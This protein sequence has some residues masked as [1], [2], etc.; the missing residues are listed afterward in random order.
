MIDVCCTYET[1]DYAAAEAGETDDRGYLWQA[2]PHTFRELVAMM[3]EFYQP[4]DY[5]VQPGYGRVSFSVNDDTDCTTGTQ[6]I[7]TIHLSNPD[8][9]RQVRYWLKAYH[10][11][12][13]DPFA[14]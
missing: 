12:N 7:R 2:V 13:R 9:A 10:T 4:S 6:T 8:D 11:A 5:P 3:G 1:W 14:R